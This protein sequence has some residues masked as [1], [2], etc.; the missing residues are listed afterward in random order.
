MHVLSLDLEPRADLPAFQGPRWLP[1][2]VRVTK[3]RA[4][5]GAVPDSAAPFSHVVLSGSTHSVLDDHDFVAPTMDLVRDAVARGVPVLGI[6]YGH[7]LV[8]RALLGKAHVRRS[9]TPEFGWLPVGALPP[10]KALFAGLPDPFHTFVGHFDEVFDLPGGWEVTAR[11]DR[12][13]VH[14]YVNRE[15]RVLGFQF[16]PEMDLVVGN[17]CFSADREALTG[18][19][20]DIDAALAGG[21]DDGSGRILFPRFLAYPW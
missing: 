5:E 20:F 6:C 14:G 8:V 13:A 7:Q 11:T 4:R 17:R 2:D 9:G 10:G 15:L 19:G 3:I 12:C 16:H 1:P 21:R 18:L